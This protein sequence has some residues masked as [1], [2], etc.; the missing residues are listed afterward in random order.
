[1]LLKTKL[2]A[3]EKEIVYFLLSTGETYGK[4]VY[5]GNDY[6]EIKV[7]NSDH[8]YSETILLRPELIL[9]VVVGGK[10]VNKVKAELSHNLSS[11]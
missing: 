6:I 2:K 11:S 5:V 8:E 7:I 1:M 3:L 10:N 9:A 4:I